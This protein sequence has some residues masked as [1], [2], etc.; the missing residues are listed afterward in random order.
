M[1]ADASWRLL[2]ADDDRLVRASTSTLQARRE[3]DKQ[4]LHV[5]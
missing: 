1:M 4:F 3:V 5:R 2:V